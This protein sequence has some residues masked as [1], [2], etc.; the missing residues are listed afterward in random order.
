M[1]LGKK[2][3]HQDAAAT[4]DASSAQGLVLHLDANDEDSIESG[5]AN[6]GNGSGTWF[7][8]ANHDLVTPL[9]DKSSNLI[10]NLDGGVYTSGAWQDQS[11]NTNNAALNGD[12]A[13]N[14]DVRGY[15]TLDGTG[16]YLQISDNSSLNLGAATYEMWFRQPSYIT[17]EHFFGRFEGDGARDF[18]VR[19]SGTSG[20]VDATFYNGSTSI[21]GITSSNGAYNA[22]EW[23][24]VAVTLAGNTSGSAVKLYVNGTLQ[25]ST[26][27][28]ANRITDAAADLFLGILGSG[29]TTQFEFTG[30]IGTTRIYNVALTASEVA[31]NF[32]AGN[33]LS[34][35]SIY[36]TN[37]QMHLDAGDTTTVSASTWSDKANSFDGTFTNFS[38]TLTDFYDKE[39]GNF[40]SFDGS[41]DHIKINNTALTKSDGLNFSVE[42]WVK[43]SGGTDYIASNTSDDGNDQ[44]WLLRFQS[45]QVKFFVYGTDEYLSTS[46]TFS[47]NTWH[48][49]VGLVESDG[50]VRIYVNGVLNISSSS[51]KS[52]NTSSYNTFI[53]SLGSQSTTN[54]EIGQVRIYHTALNS[55][56]VAQNY[57][58]TKNDYPNGNNFSNSGAT[59]TASS[60]PY[61]FQFDGSNDVMNRTLS[62]LS[63]RLT[64]AYTATF[65]IMGDALG[66]TEIA[67]STFGSGAGSQ[68]VFKSGPIVEWY[69]NG[70]STL[71]MSKSVS[72]GVWYFIC[73]T[74]DGTNGK[75]Y[76]NTT[77]SFD[78]SPATD[79]GSGLSAGDA[80]NATI[81]SGPSYYPTQC[82]IA[83]VRIYHKALSASELTTIWTAEKDT[84]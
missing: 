10:L 47:A 43:Q 34:Y 25:G 30:D 65:W 77:S 52:A 82:K 7:D 14:S 19:T 55:T 37:L 26:T 4:G 20:G 57:L 50:T 54:A 6:Q 2:L 22:N 80:T 83:A 53:G 3:F 38:S 62:N 39:L 24:H 61:Y 21:A 58:A 9:A 67:W 51:G 73:V 44:N 31:Q 32:R 69:H 23:S 13:Y 40:I 78:S 41:N 59:F 48:H 64:N 11:T 72:Q 60:A 63:Y 45:N 76:L 42:V 27:L 81:G 84:F 71:Q 17:D 8:I 66:S 68:L 74:F 16:D 5:G 18:F 33:F 75:L 12:A 1:S 35:S 49:I 46:D 79:T 29:F 56:Q 15:F 28:S 70:T 36:S